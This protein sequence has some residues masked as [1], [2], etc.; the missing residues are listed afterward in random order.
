MKEPEEKQE[1]QYFSSGL[2]SEDGGHL[3]AKP[4][5]TIEISSKLLKK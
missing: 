4:M 2:K 1:S 3:W 5:V